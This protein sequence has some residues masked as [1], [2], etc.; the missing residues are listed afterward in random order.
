MT[1][2]PSLSECYSFI[3]KTLRDYVD[4]DDRYVPIVACWVIGTYFHD[5]MITFPYLYINA[6]KGGG[7]TRMLRLLSYLSKDG[8]M[9]VNPS[10]SVIF[11]RAAQKTAFF[12][13]EIERISRKEKTNLRLLLNAAYKRGIKVPRSKKIPQTED[14]IV[15]EFEVF[16]PIAMANIWGLDNVLQ[17]RCITV[18]LD[19]S[20]DPIIVKK[21]ELWEFDKDISKLK[22][23]LNDTARL[24]F[25]INS[26]EGV[27]SVVSLPSANIYNTFPLF[28]NTILTNLKTT[29]NNI[30]TTQHLTTH[31]NTNQQV[32]YEQMAQ[33]VD[34]SNTDGVEITAELFKLGKKIWESEITGRQLELFF[35]LILVAHMVSEEV[36]DA[37]IKSAIE[38]SQEKQVDELGENRD[39]VFLDYLVSSLDR[40]VEWVKIREMSKEFKALEDE[41]WINSKWI[42]RALKRLKIVKKKRR[43]SAGREVKLDWVK[44]ETKCR[45]LGIDTEPIEKEPEPTDNQLSLDTPKILKDRGSK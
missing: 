16:T 8:T 25:S 45:Q 36:E 18:I 23:N 38:I 7:K 21:V 32:N 33:G 41:M 26:N 14:Y 37:V 39:N 9:N 17:D 42:G 15:E 29:L 3:V 43:M 28:W 10:E 44:I 24:F 40:D 5:A 27:V 35:P 6:T 19:K 34:W 30:T 12:L 31:N 22:R 4:I 1:K 20:F 11:R 2:Q 13:D